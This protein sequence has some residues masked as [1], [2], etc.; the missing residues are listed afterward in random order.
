M[1]KNLEKDF[2]FVREIGI[3]FI[4]L[5]SHIINNKIKLKI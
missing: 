3:G 5:S 1:R 4:E 2:Q